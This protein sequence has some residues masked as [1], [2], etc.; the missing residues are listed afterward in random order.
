MLREIGVGLR[1]I[2][3]RNASMAELQQQFAVL[4]PQTDATYV[5]QLLRGGK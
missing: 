3:G 2:S 1:R 4:K 5:L